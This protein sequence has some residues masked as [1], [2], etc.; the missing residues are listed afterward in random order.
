[1]TVSVSGL[2][3]YLLVFVR[4][5]ACLAFNPIFN[6]TAWPSQ[7]RMGFILL[8]TLLV[9]P[10]VPYVELGSPNFPQMVGYIIIEVLVGLFLGFIIQIYSL[11]LAF[12]GEILDSQF[13]LAMAKNFDPATDVQSGAVGGILNML[14]VMFI[15]VSN[16]HL[17]MIEAFVRTFEIIPFGT[18]VNVNT[19]CA[20]VFSTFIDTFNLVI[21]LVLPFVVC[22]FLLEISLGILMKMIPQI[23]VFVINI[24][25]KILLGILLMILLSGSLSMYLNNYIDKAVDT[26]QNAIVEISLK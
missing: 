14:L 21:R 10:N 13:G 16:A 8:L 11:L 12:A 20:F 2:I 17:E 25:L 24:Q 1:M 7:T 5:V 23:H 9:A 26:M 18:F 4:L 22:E 19:I 3:V 6:R 15:L